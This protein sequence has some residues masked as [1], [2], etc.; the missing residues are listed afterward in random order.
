MSVKKD[1]DV[2]QWQRRPI[3]IIKISEKI[4]FFQEVEIKYLELRQYFPRTEAQETDTCLYTVFIQT[5]LGSVEMKYIESQ[6][7]SQKLDR[8]WCLF[9]VRIGVRTLINRMMIEL[10]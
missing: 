10:E 8:I 6:C 9:R 5:N 1:F 7:N 2:S 3:R 4:L